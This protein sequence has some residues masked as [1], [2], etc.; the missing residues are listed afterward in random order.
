MNVPL[1]DQHMQEHNG[2]QAR[3]LSQTFSLIHPNLIGE[4]V[5]SL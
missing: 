3:Q 5:D 2:N 4:D 1:Q